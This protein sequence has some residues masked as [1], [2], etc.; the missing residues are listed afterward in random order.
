MLCGGSTV[1][2]MGAPRVIYHF[3]ITDK[4]HYL[5]SKKQ[6]YIQKQIVCKICYI[7][8]DAHT[9]FCTS[10]DFH[11]ASPFVIT[12]SV[13]QTIKVWECR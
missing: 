2:I 9:H 12:G 1:A 4:L 11:R 7:R 8:L 10:V 13:D 5:D 3:L 6:N